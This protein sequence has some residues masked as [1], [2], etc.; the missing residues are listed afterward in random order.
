MNE[1]A[2]GDSQAP[3]SGPEPSVT[4]GFGATLAQARAR[5][6]LSVGEVA[7]QVPPA[8]GRGAGA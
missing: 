4:A 8:T 7:A 6:G 2:A 1:S 5:G 3:M